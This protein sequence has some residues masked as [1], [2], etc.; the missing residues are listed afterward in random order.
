MT[1][2]TKAL[3]GAVLFQD[4]FNG[5]TLDLTKWSVNIRPIGGP[6]GRTQTFFEPEL[7]DGIARFRFD[8]YNP[9]SPGA[10]FRGSEILTLNEFRLVDALVFEARLRFNTP[11]PEGLVAAFFTFGRDDV[12]LGFDEIDVEILGNLIDDINRLP[13]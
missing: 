11:F 2:A 13:K 6:L 12:T 1:I 10:L 4:D 9:E 7:S 5:D 3:E 8:T